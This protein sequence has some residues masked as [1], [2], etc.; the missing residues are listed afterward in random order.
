MVELKACNM[1]LPTLFAPSL[2]FD[3][4]NNSPQPLFSFSCVG[5]LFLSVCY[6]SCISLSTIFIMIALPGFFVLNWHNSS[7]TAG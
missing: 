1:F 6:V 2:S 5:Y 3:L 7:S 4:A